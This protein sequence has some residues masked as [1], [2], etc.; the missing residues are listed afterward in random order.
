ME[1]D[2]EHKM[3]VIRL[4]KQKAREVDRMEEAINQVTL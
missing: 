2:D 3:R 4:I 1:M